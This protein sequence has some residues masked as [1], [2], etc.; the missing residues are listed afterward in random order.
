MSIKGCTF[1]NGGQNVTQ[2]QRQITVPSLVEI[3]P[4]VLEKN[5][6][7]PSMDFLLFHFINSSIY[8]HNLT[9][10]SPW[11]RAQPL[12]RTKLNPLYPGWTMQSFVEIGPLVLEK[13]FTQGSS[14][15]FSLFHFYLSLKKCMALY[16]NKPESPSP[17]SAL[18]EVWLKFARWQE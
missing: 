1:R 17:R 15:D 2:Q 5:F 6:T 3:C 10:I 16:L 9:I 12:T 14:M 13:K 18:C 11:K 8:F 4:L 7:H